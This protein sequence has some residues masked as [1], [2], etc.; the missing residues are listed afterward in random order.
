[1]PLI[2]ESIPQESEM[3]SGGS[4]TQTVVCISGLA[5][6]VIGSY[7][8]LVPVS[9]FPVSPLSFFPCSLPLL[10]SLPCFFFPVVLLFFQPCLSPSLIPPSPPYKSKVH[11]SMQKNTTLS[12]QSQHVGPRPMRLLVRAQ[13]SFPASFHP[14]GR[15]QPNRS[16]CQISES[17]RERKKECKYVWEWELGRRFLLG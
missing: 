9:L 2:R 3:F 17:R 4:E 5:V 11:S 8:P 13:E 15:D 10:L 7:T 1:M 16:L 6:Y 14:L 12:R